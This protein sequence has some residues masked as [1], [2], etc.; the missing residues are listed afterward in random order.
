MLLSPQVPIN[1]ASPDLR[2]RVPFYARE[3]RSRPTGPDLRTQV[4]F[5]AWVQTLAKLRQEPRLEGRRDK[6]GAEFRGEPSS[7]GS[8]VQ[9]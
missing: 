5:Y 8:Q 6:R 1:V 9:T 7:E 3:S 2:L 4:P